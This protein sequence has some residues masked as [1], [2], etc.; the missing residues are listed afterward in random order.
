[1]NH[2]YLSC[3]ILGPYRDIKSRLPVLLHTDLSKPL[4]ALTTSGSA[5][6][7]Y[8]GILMRYLL[9]HAARSN[10]TTLPLNQSKMCCAPPP[11]SICSQSRLLPESDEKSCE[12]ISGIDRQLPPISPILTQDRAH[13]PQYVELRAHGVVSAALRLGPTTPWLLQHTPKSLKYL[14]AKTLE[15]CVY[16]DVL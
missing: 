2:K 12:D 9:M 10:K 1:M 16:L 14:P 4:K 7:G 5:N 3:T 13:L 6:H 15:N 11:P 8:I